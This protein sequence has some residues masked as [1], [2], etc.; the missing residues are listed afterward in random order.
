VGAPGTLVDMKNTRMEI[1]FEFERGE[2]CALLSKATRTGDCYRLPSGLRRSCTRPSSN[3]GSRGTDPL[4]VTGERDTG[5]IFY[6]PGGADAH[7]AAAVE[8]S[9]K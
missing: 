3:A 6:E 1:L 2:Q 7:R 9:G 8:V 4:R 5:R